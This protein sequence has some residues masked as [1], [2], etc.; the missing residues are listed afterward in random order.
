[1]ADIDLTVYVVPRNPPRRFVVSVKRYPGITQREAAR[2][3][4]LAL[5]GWGFERVVVGNG[6]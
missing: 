4:R 5:K 1:M 6:K 3:I 2:R